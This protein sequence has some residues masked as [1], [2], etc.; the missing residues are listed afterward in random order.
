[1]IGQPWKSPDD[2][3]PKVSSRMRWGMCRSPPALGIPPIRLQCPQEQHQVL[4]FGLRQ[5]GTQ[6]EIEEF[7]RVVEGQQALIMQVRRRVLDAA[8]RE[9]L[10]WPVGARK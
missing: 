9:G 6:H 2:L 1:M 8:Q 5:L 7:D 10:D 4:L 3:R